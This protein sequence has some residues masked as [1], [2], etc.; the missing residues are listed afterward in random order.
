MDKKN[1]SN[2][3]NPPF[4]KYPPKDKMDT[5]ITCNNSLRLKRIVIN[6]TSIKI[7]RIMI[8]SKYIFFA[9]LALTYVRRLL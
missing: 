5:I 8:P 6:P 1:K 4:K 7:I 9:I 2:I 3:M